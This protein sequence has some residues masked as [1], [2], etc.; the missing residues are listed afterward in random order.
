M[1]PYLDAAIYLAGI[2]QTCRW[3]GWLTFHAF[4][5]LTRPADE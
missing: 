1:T 4:D 5:Y 3:M 2:F